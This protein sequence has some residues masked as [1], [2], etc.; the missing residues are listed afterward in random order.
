MLKQNDQN[1]FWSDQIL[2]GVNSKNWI[3]PIRKSPYQVYIVEVKNG[4]ATIP[5]L[6]LSHTHHIHS[7]QIQA[8]DALLRYL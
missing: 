1:L 8:S 3:E 2:L 7:A 6:G 5:R 4:S